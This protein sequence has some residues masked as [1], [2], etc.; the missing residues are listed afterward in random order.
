M[1]NKLRERLDSYGFQVNPDFEYRHEG[2]E[3]YVAV[4]TNDKNGNL[5]LII[6]DYPYIMDYKEVV[7]WKPIQKIRTAG[8]DPVSGAVVGYSVLGWIGAYIASQASN[9]HEKID[10]Y[11]IEFIL[12]DYKIPIYLLYNEKVTRDKLNQV[13]EFCNNFS[14][15]INKIKEYGGRI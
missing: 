9:L 2:K 5:A 1:D 8:F 12:Q 15:C 6:E 13:N 10:E 7:D 11:K 3:L 4:Y 14:K